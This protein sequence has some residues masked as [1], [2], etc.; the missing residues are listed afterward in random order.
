MLCRIVAAGIGCREALTH[1]SEEPVSRR[2]W[3]SRR[4]SSAGYETV[5]EKV[6]TLST[7]GDVGSVGNVESIGQLYA[8]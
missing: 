3:N 8:A 6:L 4:L 7:K 5:A 2:T 1:R